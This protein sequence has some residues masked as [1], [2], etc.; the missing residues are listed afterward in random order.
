VRVGKGGEAESA[1]WYEKRQDRN[2]EDQEN[3]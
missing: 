3:E 1:L 2:P